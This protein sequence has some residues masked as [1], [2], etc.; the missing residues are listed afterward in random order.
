MNCQNLLELGLNHNRIKYIDVFEKVNF[1]KLEKL[2]LKGN[3]IID[4]KV[5]EK[6][7]FKGLKKLDL[8]KNREKIDENNPTIIKL[9]DKNNLD[10]Y[11]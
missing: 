3:E 11:C 7:E 6:V 2:D 10:I 9:K 5:L 1:P 8:S 4:L